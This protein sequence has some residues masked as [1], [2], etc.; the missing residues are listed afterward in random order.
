MN[1]KE[2][3]MY[4][5]YHKNGGEFVKTEISLGKKALAESKRKAHMDFSSPEEEKKKSSRWS[6]SISTASKDASAEALSKLVG[7]LKLNGGENKE[8]PMIRRR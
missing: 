7:S 3:P 4:Q 1:T 2:S 6:A 5:L 8:K